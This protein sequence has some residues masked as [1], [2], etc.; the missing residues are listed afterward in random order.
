MQVVP[1]TGPYLRQA[2]FWVENIIILGVEVIARHSRA[3]LEKSLGTAK[4]HSSP[5]DASGQ[6]NSAY[7]FL[8]SV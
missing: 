5:V 7:L 6:N 2:K 8:S 1:K 3:R 4:Y